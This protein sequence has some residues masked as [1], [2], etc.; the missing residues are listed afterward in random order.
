MPDMN[1][2][3]SIPLDQVARNFLKGEVGRLRNLRSRKAPNT[4]RS[5]KLLRQ[6]TKSRSI[7]LSQDL[8][9]REQL[10]SLVQFAALNFSNAD[11]IG[12]NL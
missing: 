3:F 8:R 4:Q 11:H 2:A 12:G 7:S 9:E 1:F 5:M 6:S 10:V